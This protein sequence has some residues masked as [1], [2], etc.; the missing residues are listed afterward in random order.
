MCTLRAAI[1]EANALAGANTITLSAQTY[2]LTIQ[3]FNEDNGAQGD[4]DIKSNLT[5]N[6]AGAGSTII[7]GNSIIT[8]DRVLDTNP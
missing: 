8:S 3:G 1:Q 7:D 2:T 6:G 4:L 5:I